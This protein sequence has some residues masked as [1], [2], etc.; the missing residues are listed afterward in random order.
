MNSY[1]A[2]YF[3][4]PETARSDGTHVEVWTNTAQWLAMLAMLI[5]HAVKFMP[6]TPSE[7]MILSSTVGRLAFPLF[8]V[9]I[10]YNVLYRTRDAGQ[11]IQRLL[12]LALLS[13][14]PFWLMLGHGFILYLNAIFTLLGGALFLAAMT[15]FSGNRLQAKVFFTIGV[16]FLILAGPFVDYQRTGI[17]TVPVIGCILFYYHGLMDAGEKG[18]WKP[19][20][21]LILSWVALLVVSAMNPQPQM[22]WAAPA[23]VAAV[24]L[25]D[26]VARLFDSA[27]FKPIR[28]YPPV[29]RLF[30]PVH[31]LIIGVASYLYTTLS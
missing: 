15:S 25:I 23:V 16:I 6:G 4:A 28:V 30:Y 29:W 20:A 26:T 10:A 27:R 2:K 8:A 14:L 9:L 22:V 18:M 13:Q 1:I 7:A 24:L 12:V 3:S 21:L 11:M 5:D 17:L 19:A 31:M